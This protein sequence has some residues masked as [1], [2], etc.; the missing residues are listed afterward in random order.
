MTTNLAGASPVDQLV[1]PGS[2][3]RC[4]C[5]RC[6]PLRFDAMRM[7]VC[8]ECGDKRCVHAGDHDAPCAKSDLY[9]HNAWVE[10]HM[11][12]QRLTPVGAGDGN[13]YVVG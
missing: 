10:R 11:R 6:E 4:W 1:R 2:E 3:A 9:A 5:L 13:T 12:R 8:P 7:V